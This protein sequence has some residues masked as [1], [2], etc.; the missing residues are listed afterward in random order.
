MGISAAI[1]GSWALKSFDYV[2]LISLY[3]ARAVSKVDLPAP[4]LPMIKI[5]LASLQ[6]LSL[7]S[8][9]DFFPSKTST[10]FKT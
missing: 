9:I 7:L 10:K 5:A 4:V 8:L 3:P 1:L 2:A 6:S